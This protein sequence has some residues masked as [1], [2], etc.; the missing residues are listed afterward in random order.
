MN[1]VG[2]SSE[3]RTHQTFNDVLKVIQGLKKG[4]VV[5]INNKLHTPNGEALIFIFS[6][7]DNKVISGCS[8]GFSNVRYADISHFKV[9]DISEIEV[10]AKADSL[11]SRV[12]S[13][14]ASENWNRMR[15][16]QRVEQRVQ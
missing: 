2:A 13:K 12:L 1:G 8:V 6:V 11:A 16:L 10:V 5:A 14:L 9:E 15:R 7:K 3:I 4:D